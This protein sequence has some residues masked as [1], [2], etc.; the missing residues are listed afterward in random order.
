[1]IERAIYHPAIH[2]RMEI[3]ADQGQQLVDDY[4]RTLAPASL[5]THRTQLALLERMMGCA[6]LQDAPDGQ[7]RVSLHGF[8]DCNAPL[9]RHCRDLLLDEGR[10]VASVNLF[11]SIVRS[12][13]TLAWR[14][15]LVD[16]PQYMAVKNVAAW[17]RRE[18]GNI[19]SQRTRHKLPATRRA[20]QVMAIEQQLALLDQPDSAIGRRDALLLALALLLGL[21]L[22]ELTGLRLADVDL[23]AG[24][25]AVTRPKVRITQRLALTRSGRLTG[26]MQRYMAARAGLDCPALLLA[27]TPQRELDNRPLARDSM[28]HRIGALGLRIGIEGLSAHDLRHTWASTLAHAGTDSLALRDAGGWASVQQAAQYAQRAT[29]ANQHVVYPLELR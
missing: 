5:V 25:L 29:I 28:A 6:V 10:S 8:R 22:G 18:A 23:T 17:S 15:G 7:L 27:V 21:R 26:A 24:E 11:T 14:A 3:T 16:L 4:L 20:P 2:E 9:L 1:M 19:D 12:Y 13:V